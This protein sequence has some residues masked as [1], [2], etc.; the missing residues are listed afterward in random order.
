MV[1]CGAGRGIAAVSLL[2][3][4]GSAG[5]HFIPFSVREQLSQQGR[6]Y[7]YAGVTA[8]LDRLLSLGVRRVLIHVDDPLLIAE[9]EQRSQPHRELTLPYIVLGCKLNEFS[10]AKLM[11]VK[12]ERLAALRA[13]AEG[14]AA[15]FALLPTG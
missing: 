3:R 4:A 15:P 8:A 10:N 7:V 14:L 5:E 12:S 2:D 6:D 1:R 9:L 11:L 13:K